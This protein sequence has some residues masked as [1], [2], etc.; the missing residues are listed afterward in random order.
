MTRTVGAALGFLLVALF[1]AAV[2]V[3][4]TRATSASTATNYAAHK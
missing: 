1:F 2:A 3:E 4:A